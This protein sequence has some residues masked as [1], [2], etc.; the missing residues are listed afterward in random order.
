MDTIKRLIIKDLLALKS[1]KRLITIVF[2]LAIIFTF[3][4]FFDK[5]MAMVTYTG[6]ALPISVL[7]GLANT[8]LYEEE[9]A[10]SDSFI[11]TF[12]VNRKDI[13]L[14]KYLF[15]ITLLLIGIIFVVILGFICKLLLPLNV[16]TTFIIA[17]SFTCATNLLFVLKTPFTYKYG[18]EKAN[19]IFM[20][21]LFAILSIVPVILLSI[22][23]IDPDFKVTVEILS[24]F[25]PYLPLIIILGMIL[26]NIISFN[27]SYKIYLKKEF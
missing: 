27:I 8:I 7:G 11:L 1:Y 24:N 15:N 20:V 14:G 23:S 2:S 25:I 22:K 4:G 6:L 9:K 17:A 12:P 13:V 18:T 16:G 21:I 26:I 19:N 5:E 10:N 3:L